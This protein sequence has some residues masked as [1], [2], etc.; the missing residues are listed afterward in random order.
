MV[1]GWLTTPSGRAGL[2]RLVDS[3]AAV[4]LC[5]AALSDTS[6]SGGAASGSGRGLPADEQITWAARDALARQSLA[7]RRVDVTTVDGVVYLRGK[8]DQAANGE[9]IAAV[10]AGVPGVERVVNELK[11]AE[12]T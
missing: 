11:S 12:G 8:T 6:R 3:A 9:A 7:S 5:P 4:G 1:A 2:H 10:V